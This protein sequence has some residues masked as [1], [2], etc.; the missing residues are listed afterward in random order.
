[1]IK[2]LS[3]FLAILPILG[4][5]AA[6]YVSP[7]QGMP[8]AVLTIEGLRGVVVS[9]AQPLAA[10]VIHLPN[11]NKREMIAKVGSDISRNVTVHVD[12]EFTLY[13]GFVREK[14]VEKLGDVP[15]VFCGD[16]ISF[17][18]QAGMYYKAQLSEEEL[19]FGRCRVDLFEKFGG[20]GQWQRKEGIHSCESNPSFEDS[21]NPK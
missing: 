10:H 14:K 4:G 12:K 2:R 6:V 17:L 11:C 13:L 7:S 15:F 19:K 16:A 20:R 18:P 9:G 21:F 1:M 8:S 3:S 5:C